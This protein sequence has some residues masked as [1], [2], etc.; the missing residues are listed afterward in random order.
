MCNFVKLLE[1]LITQNESS[2]YKYIDDSTFDYKKL[3]KS[4]DEEISKS[5]LMFLCMLYDYDIT[6]HYCSMYDIIIEPS[7]EISYYLKYYKLLDNIIIY[8]LDNNK[9]NIEY[10]DASGDNVLV[11]F[12]LSNLD[13]YNINVIKKIIDTRPELLLNK[14][15]FNITAFRYIIKIKITMT[16]INVINIFLDKIITMNM[17]IDLSNELIYLCYY[18]FNYRTCHYNKKVCD[19]ILKMINNNL[20]NPAIINENEETALCGICLTNKYNLLQE[21]I[22]NEDILQNRKILDLIYK[23][24]KIN[25]RFIEFIHRH[26]SD[27][28][29]YK[30]L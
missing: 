18:D 6:L 3:F 11:Y 7:Q 27:F 24:K 1:L 21:I 19:I 30:N 25:S 8:L 9:S 23:Q 16:N 5:I 28:N 4:Y 22:H 26:Y 20:A 29:Y 14:N 10:L 15:I 13:F 17:K 2:I 12:A